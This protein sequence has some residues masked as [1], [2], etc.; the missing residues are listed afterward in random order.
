V[1]WNPKQANPDLL[2]VDLPGYGYARVSREVSATWPLFIDPYLTQRTNLALCVVL[3]DINVPPQESDRSLL[4][5]LRRSGHEFVVVATKSDKLSAN[6]LRSALS[7]LNA[8][9]QLVGIIPYSART[10]IGR[11]ELWGRIREGLSK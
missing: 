2:L 3:V 7:E 1:R 6:K 10:G 11:N 4:E 8:A 9:Y 5:F